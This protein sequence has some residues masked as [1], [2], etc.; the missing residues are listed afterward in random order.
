M[1]GD[2]PAK[3]PYIHR[4]YLQMYGSGQPYVRAKGEQTNNN[5]EHLD[6]YL[7]KKTTGTCSNRCD[8]TRALV[9]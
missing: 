5:K 4:I 2:F 9:F 8:E 1:Y 6:W 7:F 3:I